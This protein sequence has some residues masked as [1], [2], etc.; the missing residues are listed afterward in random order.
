[1]RLLFSLTVV[2]VF[3]LLIETPAGAFKVGRDENGKVVVFDNDYLDRRFGRTWVPGR[4]GNA[5]DERARD[6]EEQ[7]NGAKP[8]R[9]LANAISR[10]GSPRQ[11]AALRLAEVGRT[12]LQS[13]QH[14]KAVYYFEKALGLD[15]SPFMH[16]YL[17]RVYYELAEYQRSA[18]FLEVAES[19][20]SGQPEWRAEMESLRRE[21]TAAHPAL[22]QAASW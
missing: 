9:P 5:G 10:A 20:L 4:G 3:L 22:T 1:M 21:L 8:N 18:R 15:A 13:G 17:A 11:A 19:L 2:V 7:P 16:F 14:Q 12:S 6:S